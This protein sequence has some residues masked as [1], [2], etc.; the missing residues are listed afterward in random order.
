M[1]EVT[2]ESL[3]RRVA[4]LERQMAQLRGVIPASR[5][6]QSVVGICE[7]TE[8]SDLMLAEM[9]AFREAQRKEEG[10]DE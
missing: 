1:A 2:L 6:F 4:A 10:I 3:S 8:F 9:K 5:S 7:R